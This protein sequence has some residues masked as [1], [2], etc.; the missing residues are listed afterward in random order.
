MKDYLKT[1]SS[2]LSQQNT[3]SL[4]F[5]RN[6]LSSFYGKNDFFDALHEI[7][8]T[9]YKRSNVRTA[10]KEQHATDFGQTGKVCFLFF[11]SCYFCNNIKFD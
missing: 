5:Y 2:Q 4:S 11:S 8:H 10:K 9:A 1:F 6:E 7:G 3:N